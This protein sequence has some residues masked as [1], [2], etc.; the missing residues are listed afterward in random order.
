MIILTRRDKVQALAYACLFFE[1]WGTASYGM[2]A[3]AKG[4][5]IGYNRRKRDR[6]IGML[7]P[8][9]MSDI[10]KAFPFIHELGTEEA[11]FFSNLWHQHF[12]SS[13][14]IMDENRNCSGVIFVLSGLIRIYK[15]S[16][17]GKEITLYRIGRGETCVLTVSCLLGSGDVPF[18]VAAIAEQDASLVYMPLE[19]FKKLFFSSV[20]IQKFIFSSMSAKFY[21]VLG[22]LENITFK[23]TSER[24]MDLLISKTA[25]G[26]YPLYSTHE[27]IAAELG[28]AREVISRLLKEMEGTGCVSLSRG[29]IVLNKAKF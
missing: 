4:P 22:L 20:P 7:E 13:T 9:M 5:F 27:S 17:E 8:S 15:L 2:E 14:V 3:I 23:R 6:V 12:E 24:L 25:G 11:L 28:T 26:A 1:H 19:A 10:K 29:K 18:P 16:E 21:S